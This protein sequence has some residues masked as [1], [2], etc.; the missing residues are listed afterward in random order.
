MGLWYQGL[1]DTRAVVVAL[2]PG[3][4][5]LE[6]QALLTVARKYPAVP[7][8]RRFFPYNHQAGVFVLVTVVCLLLGAALLCRDSLRDVFVD[9]FC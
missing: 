2:S 4:S 5:Q 3:A 8:G 6:Q 1:V 9:T 7:D